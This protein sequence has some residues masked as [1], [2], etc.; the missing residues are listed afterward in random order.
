MCHGNQILPG[1]K[2]S[3][4][5]HTRFD[6]ADCVGCRGDKQHTFR[7]RAQP[8][9][10]RF[11]DLLRN[12]REQVRFEDAL[13]EARLLRS[14]SPAKYPLHLG[15]HLPVWSI[16]IALTILIAYAV[17]M[18]IIGGDEYLRSASIDEFRALRKIADAL[19]AYVSLLC[20]V[21]LASVII[22]CGWGN[23]T[24]RIQVVAEVLPVTSISHAS[25]P[26]DPPP[27][28]L[29]RFAPPHSQP[30]ANSPARTALP[31]PPE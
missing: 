26:Q 10:V 1:V 31:A 29:A 2:L 13:R 17:K 24:P 4:G 8:R 7:F 27:A 3:P 22:Q 28:P 12:N 14:F 21:N 9:C 19:S 20:V 5:F 18:A 30:P 6:G 25:V 15:I 23:A 16:I 11:W